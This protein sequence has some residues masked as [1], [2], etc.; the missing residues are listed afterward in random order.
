[1]SSSGEFIAIGFPLQ[2]YQE[3][4][5]GTVMKLQHVG[6]VD[7]YQY[8]RIDKEWSRVA[9]TIVG[10]KESGHFCTSLSFS[11]DGSIIAIGAR[12]DISALTVDQ[13]N[14][15]VSTNGGG[16][17]QVHYQQGDMGTMR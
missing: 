16:Y 5:N 8:N 15:H 12:G 7:V 13:G 2:D 10:L 17:V 1:M 6:V 14:Y 4:V 11:N 9:N 3:G